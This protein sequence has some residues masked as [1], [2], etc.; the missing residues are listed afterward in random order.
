MNLKKDARTILESAIERVEQGW[1]QGT[2][3][4]D[5]HDRAVLAE[6]QIACK[7]CVLGAMSRAAADL[8]R[9]DTLCHLDALDLASDT[10]SEVVTEYGTPFAA[11]W[12]DTPG[13]T[14]EQVIDA[15]K[16]AIGRL[17]I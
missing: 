2:M 13:R 9:A 10:V 7:W 17:R 8:R 11:N 16:D 12:N 15:I 6:S 4:R 5:K 3:A 1:V 14:K